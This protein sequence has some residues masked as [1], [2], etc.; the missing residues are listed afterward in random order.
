MSYDKP[1]EASGPFRPNLLVE[2]KPRGGKYSKSHSPGA[3]LVK[4]RGSFLPIAAS[5]MIRVRCR[6]HLVCLTASTI[7]CLVF[8]PHPLKFLSLLQGWAGGY[9][10]LLNTSFSSLVLSERRLY[11]PHL[12]TT[13]GLWDLL[14]SPSAG[15]CVHKVGCS[16]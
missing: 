3:V 9:P 2:Q 4:N 1:E 5:S 7:T 10:G 6:I 11:Y 16:F 8:R 13:M 12:Q 15:S 14:P